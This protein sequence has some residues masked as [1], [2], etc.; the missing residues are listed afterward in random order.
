M[1]TARSW[2]RL[3]VHSIK[4]AGRDDL[5]GSK[6]AIANL[7]VVF[8]PICGGDWI[9]SEISNSRGRRQLTVLATLQRSRNHDAY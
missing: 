7:G 1:T 2:R 4:G 8:P 6:K 3:E 5:H 9:A